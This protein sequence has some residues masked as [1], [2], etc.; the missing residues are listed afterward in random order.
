MYFVPTEAQVAAMDETAEVKKC[1]CT[2]NR[3]TNCFPQS[4]IKILITIFGGVILRGDD[5]TPPLS[6][7]SIH[8]FHNVDELLLVFQSP[9]DLVVIS[10]TEI[11][12]N[13]F[14]AEEKHYRARVIQLV[15]SVEIWHLW[16]INKIYNSKILDRLSHRSKNFIHLKTDHETLATTQ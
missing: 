2:C 5:Q 11:D 16:N 10:R 3:V 13:M 12:H 7:S 6:R 8:S 4:E 14:I 15:H 9:I 1:G